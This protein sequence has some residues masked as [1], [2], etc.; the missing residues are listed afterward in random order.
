MTSIQVVVFVLIAPNDLAPQNKASE[1]AMPASV[2]LAYPLAIFGVLWASTAAALVAGV[3]LLKRRNWARLS[4]IGLLCLAVLWNLG[5]VWVA[6]SMLG[7][8]STAPAGASDAFAREFET[9]A[10]AMRIAATLFS[11][12]IA[13]ICGWLVFR[14]M[15]KQVRAEFKSS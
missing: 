15:S 9:A 14:L 8:F 2:L 5:G 6:Q 11:L 3:G 13:A 12:V 7:H 10:A 4:S 1:L